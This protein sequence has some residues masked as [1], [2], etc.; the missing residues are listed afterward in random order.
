MTRRGPWTVTGERL[1][2][3]NPWMRVVE[4]DVIRPD[5]APGLYGVM[6][7]RQ[8]AVGVLPI[9][10]D[11]TTVLVSQ[12]RFTFDRLSWEL[13]EG[14]GGFDEDPLEAA[15]RELKEET[16]ATAKGW[17]RILEMDVSNSL[18]DERAIAF[19]AWDV[20]EGTP[21]RDGT[22]ADMTTRRI[23]VPEALRLAMEG[24]IRDAFT[25]AILAKADYMARTGALQPELA[26]AVLGEPGA[27]PAQTGGLR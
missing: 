22:E 1:V 11:G 4:H 12:H 8:L 5:G 16:G 7:P 24:E 17:R 15:R 13:P 26:D 25:L 14:G 19:L 23:A 2:Y 10:P 20:E 9:F 21:A 18:T 27:T 6:S 3:E